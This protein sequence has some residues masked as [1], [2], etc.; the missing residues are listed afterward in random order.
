MFVSDNGEVLA[1]DIALNN[2]QVQAILGDR[3]L[4]NLDN[5]ETSE[6]GDDE[7]TFVILDIDS[8]LLIIAE[9]NIGKKEVIQVSSLELND[10]NKQEIISIAGTDTRIQ[11]LLDQGAEITSFKPAYNINLETSFVQ[12]DVEIRIT[13]DDE[14]Y[15]A[16]I[17]I[18]TEEVKSFIPLPY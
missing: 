18:E 2:P 5:M 16:L 12:L 7:H 14:L 17:D 10:E 9:V 3:Q 4:D 6:I 13:L 1:I 8:E 15:V 11:N